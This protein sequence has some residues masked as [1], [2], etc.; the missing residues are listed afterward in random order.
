MLPSSFRANRFAACSVLVN[1]G[2]QRE[3]AR[4]MGQG[5]CCRRGGTAKYPIQIASRLAR[6]NSG[7][8]ESGDRTYLERGGA[9]QGDTA[10]GTLAETIHGLIADGVV[11]RVEAHGVE[12]WRVDVGE[13]TRDERSQHWGHEWLSGRNW[14]DR[15][16]CDKVAGDVP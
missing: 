4:K 1:C 5:Q 9:V 11:P 15:S 2:S 16:T 10:G 13:D 6:G 14:I 12:T 3:G 7:N 8:R